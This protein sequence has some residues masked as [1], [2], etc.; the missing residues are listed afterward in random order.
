M[1]FVKTKESIGKL[2]RIACACTEIYLLCSSNRTQNPRF[3]STC[4][5]LFLSNKFGCL[6]FQQQTKCI[7]P[8]YAFELLGRSLKTSLKA[9]SLSACPVLTLLVFTTERETQGAVNLGAIC[10]TLIHPACLC[11][12][13]F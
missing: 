5:F 12:R 4:C 13:G 10:A 11:Y 6:G 8:F 1:Y 7:I 2:F 3:L 9:H